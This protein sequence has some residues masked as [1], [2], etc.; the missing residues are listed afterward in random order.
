MENYLIIQ[1]F[2]FGER[3]NFEINILCDIKKYEVIPLLFQPIVENAF[4]HGL[5][6]KE[7]ECKLIIN[8]ERNE[9]D[10]L[11]S[12]IDNGVGIEE[13]KLIIINGKLNDFNEDDEQ[14]IGLCNVNQ[15]IKLL[16]GEHYGVVIES[17]KNE[18]TIVVINLPIDKEGFIKC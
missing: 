13:N 1:K 9:N 8:I 10:L 11:I 17:E 6:T 14:R 3:I 4:V 7:G 18:G 12:V 16:Y 2:R 5:E 15:R